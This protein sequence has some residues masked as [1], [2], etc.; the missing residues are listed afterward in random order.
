MK[1]LLNNE[2]SEVLSSIL[3][4]KDIDD[5]HETVVIECKPNVFKNKHINLEEDI[6][7]DLQKSFEL[8]NKDHRGKINLIWVNSDYEKFAN[9][10]LYNINDNAYNDK[11]CLSKMSSSNYPQTGLLSA[12]EIIEIADKE[13]IYH[14][15]NSKENLKDFVNPAF[16]WVKSI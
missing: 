15:V 1:K 8:S 16:T 11:Y 5:I 12:K 7:N 4:S 13:P 9:K 3:Y 14:L 10:P 6:K 2:V